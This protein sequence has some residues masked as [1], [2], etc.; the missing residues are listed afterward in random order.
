MLFFMYSKRSWFSSIIDRIFEKLMFS[1]LADVLIVVISLLVPVGSSSVITNIFYVLV[2]IL[3]L[4]E[5]TYTYS[6]VSTGKIFDWRLSILHDQLLLSAVLPHKLLNRKSFTNG[7]I[8]L[9]F[10]YRCH[11]WQNPLIANN[12][13]GELVGFIADHCQV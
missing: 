13:L 4:L 8:S 2:H 7:D 3:K 9:G 1:C 5:L 10:S 12:R 6:L 11:I